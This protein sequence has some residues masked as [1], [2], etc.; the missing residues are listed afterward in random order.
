QMTIDVGVAHGLTAASPN[1]SL[2]AGLVVPLA[3]LW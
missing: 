3:K 1:W 2:F